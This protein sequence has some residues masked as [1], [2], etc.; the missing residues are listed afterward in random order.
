LENPGALQALRKRLDAEY[1]M[2]DYEKAEEV[3]RQF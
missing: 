3:L 2:R 1:G